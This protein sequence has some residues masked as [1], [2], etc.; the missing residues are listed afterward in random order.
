MSNPEG[1]WRLDGDSFPRAPGRGS[2]GE[3]SPEHGGVAGV[4]VTALAQSGPAHV[5]PEAEVV[6]SSHLVAVQH[7]CVIPGL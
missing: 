5:L 7:L 3:K 1:Q 4:L 2:R 6:G